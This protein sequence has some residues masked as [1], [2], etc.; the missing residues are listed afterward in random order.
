[1]IKGKIILGAVITV[2]VFIN[3]ACSQKKQ[4]PELTQL[5]FSVEESPEWS[6][7]FIRRHGWLG[8][9][10][11]FMLTM[12]GNEQLGAA[13]KSNTLLWFSDTQLGDVVNNTL[14]SKDTLVINNS[15]AVLQGDKPDS[16]AIRFYWN[17]QANGAPA[18]VFKPST[19]LSKPGEYYWL[20]DA[21]VNTAMNKDI[22]LFGYRVKSTPGVPGFGFAVTGNTL[23]HIPAGD[24]PPFIKQK[25]LDIPFFPEKDVD[26]AGAIGAGI[27]VNTKEAGAKDA[28]GYVYIYRVK[29]GAVLV[30][31]VLPEAIEK[32][33][34]W[35]CWNGKEWVSDM[36]AAKPVA[37]RSSNEM[38]VTALGDGRYL[39]V[40]Q[41]DGIGN[42]VCARLGAS[43]AG[44]FGPIIEL[45][46]A[47][48]SLAGSKHMYVYNAKAHPVIS[49]PGELLISYNINSADY[50]ND[51]KKMPNFYRPRFIKLK[52]ELNK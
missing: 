22:Y 50:F 24:K 13:A 10:G 5:K 37:D 30:C 31:R 48:G 8:G 16:S 21:F 28:D 42:K 20:S 52:Y 4:E 12:D 15:M 14:A 6:S 3:N 19:P 41:I 26:S 49:K 45:Y 44:P 46:D 34:Q 35:K 25:Q 27:F 36:Y 17:E 32:F 39:M 51:I 18:A 1:M 23:I 7:L 38:S 9:D 47:S 43:P 33:D 11:I 29:G 2:T 40:F